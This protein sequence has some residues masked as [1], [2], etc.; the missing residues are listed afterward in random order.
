MRMTLLPILIAFGAAGLGL[1]WCLGEAIVDWVAW[2]LVLPGRKAGSLTR[3]LTPSDDERVLGEPIETVAVDGVRLAGIWH[4][5]EDHS[6]GGRGRTVLVLHGFAEDPSTLRGRMEAL[7]RHGWNVAALD[8]RAH[9]RSGG[10]RITFGGR[11][12]DDVRSWVS[13]LGRMGRLRLDHSV[14]VWGRSMGATVALLAAASDPRVVAVVLESPYADL[15]ETLVSILI[16]K[17]IPFARLV[18]RLIMTRAERLAGLPP[19]LPRPIDVARKVHV[20]VLVLHG[21]E[22]RLTPR[23]VAEQLASAFPQRA[24]MIEVPGSGH[25]HIVE[26]GGATLLEGVATF[27]DRSVG[28]ADVI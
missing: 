9:G 16:R 3:E 20:P 11:E 10:D 1:L 23:S 4:E 26:V 14:A 12:A 18:M 24:R 5:A 25:N 28:M 6:K 22:D 27:L 17:R 19:H 2:F 8:T 21:S 13:A 15:E 7:G